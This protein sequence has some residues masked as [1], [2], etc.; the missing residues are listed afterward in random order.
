M[1]GGPRCTVGGRAILQPGLEDGDNFPRLQHALLPWFLFKH[2]AAPV[3]VLNNK[4]VASKYCKGIFLDFWLKDYPTRGVNTPV[5][6]YI[7]EYVLLV[8]LWWSSSGRFYYS[9]SLIPPKLR[10]PTRS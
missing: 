6:V 7:K 3:E 9:K 2:Q 1:G 4:L 5:R 10:K 8:L